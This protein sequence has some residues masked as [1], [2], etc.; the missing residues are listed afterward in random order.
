MNKY[1]N[2]IDDIVVYLY[3]RECIMRVFSLTKPLSRIYVNDVLHTQWMYNTPFDISLE[4]DSTLKK[5]ILDIKYFK[6]S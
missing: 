6:I 1:E 4:Q 3:K 2:L 5:N